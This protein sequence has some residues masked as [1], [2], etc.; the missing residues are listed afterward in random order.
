MIGKEYVK[1]LRD[2]TTTNQRAYALLY[3]LRAE[4]GKVTRD[5]G[6]DLPT[7]REWNIAKSIAEN[8]AAK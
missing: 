1:V 2:P 3:Y 8:E 7:K 4:L 5:L 6:A